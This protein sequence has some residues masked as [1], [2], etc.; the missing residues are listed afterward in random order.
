MTY[1]ITHTC[2]EIVLLSTK[3]E[4]RILKANVPRRK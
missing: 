2:Y 4:M 3:T 1:T